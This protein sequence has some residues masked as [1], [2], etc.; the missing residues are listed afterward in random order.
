MF[1]FLREADARFT[2]RVHETLL[3]GLHGA[4]SDIVVLPLQDA[5]GG[6]E[7]INIPA[8]VGRANWNYRMPWPV[9]AL[10]AGEAVACAA[11]LAVH[12][13]RSRR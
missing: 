9:E 5:Y 1:S 10:D 13:R 7:R 4:G 11:A 2:P 3:A 6:V 12:V 8:T